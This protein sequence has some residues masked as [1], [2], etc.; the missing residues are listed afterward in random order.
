MATLL[1]VPAE[2]HDWHGGGNTIAG[3][4]SITSIYA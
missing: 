2:Q 1:K 4:Q 3:Y